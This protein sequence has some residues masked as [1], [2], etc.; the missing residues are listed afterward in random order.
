M[1]TITI[2]RK[3]LEQA[4]ESF[5]GYRREMRLMLGDE[6]SE[7]CDVEKAIR[8]TLTAPATAPEPVAWMS[9]KRFY[10]TRAMALINGEQLIEPLYLRPPATAPAQPDELEQLRKDA[11]RYRWCVDNNLVLAGGTREFGWQIAPVGSEWNRFIDA[12]MKGTP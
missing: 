3:L 6:E 1:T 9:P 11:E 8:A 7:P 2:E 10:R 5:V 12:A 4:V